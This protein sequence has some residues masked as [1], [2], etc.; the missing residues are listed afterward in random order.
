MEYNGRSLR[1]ELKFLI[2]P[3][4][5]QVLR[6]R[7]RLFLEPDAH[8]RTEGYRV[9]SLYFDDIYAS[10]YQEKLSGIN[11]RRKYRLRYYDLDTGFL[12]LEVK[13]KNGSLV[14]KQG[15]T[16]TAQE[17]QS[18]LDQDFHFAEGREE[19]ALCKAWMAHQTTG[20]KPVLLADYFREAYVSPFGNVRITFDSRLQAALPP[21][22]LQEKPYWHLI[23]TEESILEVKFDDF[24]PSYIDALLAPLSLTHLSLSKYILCRDK[25]QEVQHHAL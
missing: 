15:V 8:N 16:V 19:R 11:D 7:L 17:A 25:L 13:H 9:T 18:M 20:L 2:S 12:R 14:S 23:M 10:G 22:M 5:Q 1:H 21:S 24:L 3:V 4:Q 6:E